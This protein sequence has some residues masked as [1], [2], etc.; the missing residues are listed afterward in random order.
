MG[1]ALKKGHTHTKKTKPQ[2]KN[3]KKPVT[4]LEIVLDPSGC[5]LSSTRLGIHF[6]CLFQM[7]VITHA[8][9]NQLWIGGSKDPLVGFH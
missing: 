9:T 5:R 6:I 8:S 3:N 4:Y 7:Q 1:A 2:T